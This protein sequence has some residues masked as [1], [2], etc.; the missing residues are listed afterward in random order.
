MGDFHFLRPEW[1]LVLIPAIFIL[2]LLWRNQLGASAWHSVFDEKLLAQ[3]WL[4]PPGKVSRKPLLLIGLGWVLAIIALAGPA[5]ER[6]PEQVWRSPLSRIIILDLSASMNVTDVTPSR[7][8][9]ARFKLM[10]ILERS[11]EGRTGLIVFAGEPHIVTPLTEDSETI[12]NLLMAL[13]PEIVPQS[14]DMATPALQMAEDL[15]AQTGVQHGELLLISDGVEDPAAALDQIRHLRAKGYRVSVLGVGTEQGGAILNADGGFV[16]FS[17]FNAAPLQEFANAGGGAFSSMTTDDSDLDRVLLETFRA[18]LADEVAGSGVERWVESGVLLLPILLLLGAFAFRRGWLLG[19]SLL[20]IIPPPAQAFDWRE[21]WL[22]SDQQAE[23]I[24]QQGDAQGAAQKFQDPNWRGMALYE[25]GD[26]QAAAE[27]FAESEL[28]DG[29][30]NK[31]NALAR[32]GDLKQA[33]TAYQDVLAEDPEHKDARANLELVKR[34]LEDQQSSQDD[35]SSG[36]DSSQQD[37]ESQQDDGNAN[38]DSTDESTQDDPSG[39]QSSD[40]QQAEAD[41][42]DVS[43]AE[44]DGEVDASESANAMTPEQEEMT[45]PEDEGEHAPVHQTESVEELPSEEDIALEQW[46]RQIPED[47]AGLLRR[48]FLL[49]HLQRKNAQ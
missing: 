6:Q 44:N 38:E 32:A 21:L 19:V 37:D 40:G 24:L 46:L 22:R 11:R 47:P 28:L 1:L 29:K 49:E 31:G 48:K 7:L 17:Q 42:A 34:L 30:Y 3:L 16:A 45:P 18:D 36:D 35:E 27:A 14:G 23:E 15:L 41:Q 5:W 4:E 26:Y 13:S 12:S 33:M 8:E 9:R 39:Q 43:D 10:D 20:M 25:T 2:T